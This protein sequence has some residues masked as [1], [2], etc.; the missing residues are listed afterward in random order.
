M[1]FDDQGRPR[2]RISFWIPLAIFVLAIVLAVVIIKNR[3]RP[4]PAEQTEVI[5]PEIMV[6]KVS[7]SSAHP[8]VSTTGRVSSP[9]EIQIISRVSGV[10]QFVSDNFRDGASFDTKDFLVQ[11]EDHDYAVGLAQAE[12]SLASAQQLLATEQGLS[13]Q[14]KR[15][16]RDLGNTEANS[17]FLREPQLNSAKAQVQAA[18][19][20]LEQAKLNLQR[21]RI[22]TPFEGVISARH[23]DVGQ[24]VTPG[25]PIAT[26]HS[27]AKVQVNISLTPNE[28]ADLGWQAR[29]DVDLEQMSAQI[30]YRLGR[31]NIV[32]Q[33]DI[34]HI[35]PLVDTMTQMTE[36]LVDLNTNQISSA[37]PPP[38]QFVEARLT[39]ESIDNA[40]WVPESA[41]FEREQV[42]LA[43]N[44]QLE[45]RAINVVANADSQILAV[46]LDDGDMV[47]IDRPLWVFPGEEVTPVLAED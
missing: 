45:I 22:T 21:T 6:V 16:W 19:F 37:T 24:F 43:N 27:T 12:A 7:N 28:I 33:G 5:T 47:V 38:G 1:L 20:S 10:I 29:G 36:V 4:E 9:H 23:A 44:N 8:V 39:G 18:Q 42:L 25:T 32:V 15:E 46:G 2:A 14:A 34:K 31:D 35:S 41:L 30:S 3:P 13:D 17:L 11:V 26:V 40:M